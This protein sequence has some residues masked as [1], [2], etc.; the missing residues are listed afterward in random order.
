MEE[1]IPYHN[2]KLLD[3]YYGN[4]FISMPK[5]SVSGNG[6]VLSFQSQLYTIEGLDVSELDQ[7]YLGM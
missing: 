1:E 7:L 6:H 3:L 4:S 5:V 2:N